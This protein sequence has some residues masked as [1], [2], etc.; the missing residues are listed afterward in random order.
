MSESLS[1][2]P[3]LDLI[4]GFVAVGRRLSI[5][6]A[7]EDLC[8]TQSAVSRQV[9]A[10]EEAVGC[11]LLVRRHR[12]LSFTPDGE[13]LFREADRMLQHL[14]ETLA[15]L[16]RSHRPVTINASIGVTSLWLLPRLGSLQRRHPE[17]DLRVMANNRLLDP[18]TEAMDLT[19]RYCRPAAAPEGAL[20]LFGESIAPVAHPDHEPHRLS[21]PEDLSRHVLLEFDDPQRPWLQWGPWLAGQGWSGAQPRAVLHFNQYDQAIHAALAGRGIALGR[22]PLLSHPLAEGHLRP[23]ETG[24]APVAVDHAYW[25]IQGDRPAG[26][27]VARVV[28]WIRTETGLPTP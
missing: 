21:A 9:Q 10:L 4:K 13:C 22:L 6:R 26:G 27:D 23:V 3:S 28:D 14:Q 1:R 11:Q 20:R 8:L 5:T 18:R 2:L 24:A 25:L 12:A 15:K 19:I 7:A 16:N 17:I